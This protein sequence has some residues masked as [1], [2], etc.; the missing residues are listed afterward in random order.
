MSCLLALDHHQQQPTNQQA[1]ESLLLFFFSCCFAAP[2]KLHALLCIYQCVQALIFLCVASHFLTVF[3]FL[4]LPWCTSTSISR[5]LWPPPLSKTVSLWHCKLT[6]GARLS[7]TEDW[8]RNLSPAR[9]QKKKQKITNGSWRR[10]NV[11]GE[12]VAERKVTYRGTDQVCRYGD[13]TSKATTLTAR[14]WQ[15]RRKEDTAEETEEDEDEETEDDD[16]GTSKEEDIVAEE[17][18]EEEDE[19]ER[20]GGGGY[21]AGR[22]WNNGPSRR[23]FAGPSRCPL[24]GERRV[25]TFGSSSCSCCSP[26]SSS[27]CP[28]G[29]WM[30]NWKISASSSCWVSNSNLSCH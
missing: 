8:E 24:S 26:S 13:T 14:V 20:G 30:R 23:N 28:R 5:K 11:R 27:S 10:R 25:S 16:I 7:D 22:G 12:R 15:R 29:W 19:K 9:C 4:F 2:V 6:Q 18:R 21:R 17:G 3:E 1:Y